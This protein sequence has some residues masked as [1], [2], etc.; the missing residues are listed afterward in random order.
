MPTVAIAFD[1]LKA[2]TLDLADMTGSSFPDSTIL[3]RYLNQGIGVLHDLIIS[4]DAGYSKATQAISVLSGTEAYALPA[5]F[6]RTI[7]M[8]QVIDGRRY[9]I[10]QHDID[11]VEGT[12]VP[13]AA[14]TISHWYATEHVKLGTG[15]DLAGYIQRGWERLIVVHAAIQLMNR[16]E[17]DT[18]ALWREKKDIMKQIANA[19]APRSDYLP[20]T[21]RDTDGHYAYGSEYN[22]LHQS[23][24]RSSTER[25][26]YRIMG[27]YVEFAAAP[28]DGI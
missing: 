4:I 22:A 27:Q 2:E 8:W 28:L 10:H 23:T 14:A 16:E 9:R 3:E 5:D 17:S 7:A 19:V 11:E 21:I 13:G 1:D 20:E 25:L 26:T 15:D 24:H 18:S 6:Q 12:K